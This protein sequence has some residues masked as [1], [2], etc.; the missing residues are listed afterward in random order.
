[1][2]TFKTRSIAAP[3]SATGAAL[4]TPDKFAMIARCDRLKRELKI[5]RNILGI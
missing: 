4:C 3:K 2:K 1:M 5:N